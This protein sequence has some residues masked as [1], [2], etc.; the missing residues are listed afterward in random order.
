MLSRDLW[1]RLRY[2]EVINYL[3]KSDGQCQASVIEIH[4]TPPSI[5][6]KNIVN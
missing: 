4:L 1:K 6:G 2:A 5:F 3:E